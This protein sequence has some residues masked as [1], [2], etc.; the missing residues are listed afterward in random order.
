MFFAYLLYASTIVDLRDELVGKA[1]T[2]K[3]TFMIQH[4]TG[5][6]TTDYKHNK[7]II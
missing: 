6:N 5:E 7:S 2:K 1:D 3:S 4:L